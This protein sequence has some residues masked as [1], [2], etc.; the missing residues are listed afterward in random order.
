MTG[1]Q[2]SP[3]GR[4]D[5]AS[6]PGG[7]APVTNARRPRRPDSSV[8][9]AVARALRN[10]A[11]PQERRLWL[12]LRALRPQGLHFRRQVPID[13]FVVDF[14]CLRHKLIVELDG[15][16]HNADLHASRDR[17][18][19]ERLG[20]LGFAVLRFWNSDLVAD[21]D[22]VVETIFAHARRTPPQPSPEGEGEISSIR[23]FGQEQEL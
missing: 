17:A 1:A 14:A 15:G 12:Q 7:V 4:A 18:R 10:N 11:T 16:Q 9:V 21:L 23:R 5:R 19:D 13:R 20:A 3:Q 6:G 8:S 2:P 22:S